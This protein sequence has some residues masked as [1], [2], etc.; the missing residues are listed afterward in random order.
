MGKKQYKKGDEIGGEYRV[1][2]VFGGENASGMGVVYLV[3]NREIPKPIVLKTFQGALSEAQK[4]R[5]LVEA[6]AWISAGA[7]QH[8]VQAYW[9][10]EIAGQ[11]YIA[12]EYVCR[13]SRQAGQNA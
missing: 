7:H 12:A 1:H 10:R 4:R 8:L 9:V 3:T 5:F 2:D 13:A 6:Q 11:L